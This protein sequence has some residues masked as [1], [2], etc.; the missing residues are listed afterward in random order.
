MSRDTQ[1]ALMRPEKELKGFAKVAL[2]PGETHTVTFTPGSPGAGLLRRRPHAAG[3]PRPESSQVLVGRSA[4]DIRLTATFKLT[5]TAR[6]DGPG[7]A[8]ARLGLDSTLKDLLADEGTRAILDRHIPGFSSN[9]QVSFAQSFT[10]TQVAGFDPQTFSD[11]VL[12][13]IAADL[14]AARPGKASNGPPAK[15]AERTKRAG[16]V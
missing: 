12:H 8:A 5:E 7:R 11:A 1:S 4:Q 13:A 9:P 2:A 6:F 14:E 15:R 16:Q 10:L 3:W